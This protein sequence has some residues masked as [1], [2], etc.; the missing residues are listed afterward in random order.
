M[1]SPEHCLKLERWQGPPHM[2]KMKEHETVL[3]CEVRLLIQLIQS[4]KS[5]FFLIIIHHHFLQ[6]ILR[7]TQR[8]LKHHR[9]K[10]N[11][12][13]GQSDSL[14]IQ[15]MVHCNVNTSE[16]SD[17]LFILDKLPSNE[18]EHMSRG[19]TTHK[20]SEREVNGPEHGQTE[21]I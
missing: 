5:Y 6:P 19:P 2:N 1:K 13:R 16:Y 10:E 8:T 9:V 20:V 17:A 21:N 4:W 3:S 18:C 12:S 14:T 15:P 11:T 7:T